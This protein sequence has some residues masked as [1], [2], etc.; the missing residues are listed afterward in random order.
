MDFQ[1]AMATA[2]CVAIVISYVVYRN[3]VFRTGTPLTVR[4]IAAFLL[5][6]AVGLLVTVLVAS[7]VLIL[8]HHRNLGGGLSAGISHAL[9]ILAGAAAT[10]PLHK[11]VTFRPS[12][13]SAR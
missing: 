5:T 9:G 13:T 10:Y 8:L 11:L 1:L 12:K 2:G 4:S 7:G 3:L 6:N